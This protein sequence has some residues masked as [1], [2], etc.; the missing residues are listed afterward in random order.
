MPNVGRRSQRSCPLNRL[1]L[2]SVFLLVFV[3]LLVLAPSSAWAVTVTTPYPDLT[4]QA[5]QEVNLDLRVSDNVARRVDL[6]LQNVPSGWEV[7]ITGGGYSIKAVMVDPDE[8]SRL[9]LKL[10]VPA[11]AAERSYAFDVVARTA[12]GTTTLPITVTVSKAAGAATT[13]EAEYSSLKGPASATYTFQL[14]L[15][16]D[17]LEP[18]TY[19]LSVTGP[20][21]WTTTLKPSG[22]TQETPTVTVEAQ[23]SQRLNLEVKPSP[24]VT[25]GTY[26]LAVT[27]SGGGEEI[28]APLQVTIT[29]TYTLTVTTPDGRLN[30]DI[31]AGGTTRQPLVVTNSGTGPLQGVKLS[32]SAPSGWKVTFDPPAIDVLPPNQQQTVYAVF[33]P[34]EDAIAGDYVVSVSA[35]ADQ[36][37]AQEELRVTVKTSTLWGVIGVIIA[38]AAIVILGLIF[39]R[40][41]H[42]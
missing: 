16:N 14:T 19:N 38:V 42:R 37:I 3:L 10:K 24:D 40:F 2:G 6:S 17:S 39:R 31:K 5:G 13:L 30:F 29:G 22:A 28:S 23:S 15:R 32:A 36:A 33:T 27:V 21:D 26:D 20:E 34:A 25:I 35:R 12:E 9:T 8:P 4:V 1:A 7:S 18:R 11:D 41:G